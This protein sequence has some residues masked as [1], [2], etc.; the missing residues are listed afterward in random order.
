MSKSSLRRA[1]GLLALILAGGYFGLV[2]FAAACLFQGPA[3]GVLNPVP[4]HHHA[5]GSAKSAHSLLCAWAC[6][7]GSPSATTHVVGV[8][9]TVLA[10]GEVIVWAWT[11]YVRIAWAPGRP[12]SPPLRL[13]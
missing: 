11:V 4:H 9:F 8:P 2:V 13:N 10:W 6:Q 5:D 7:A 12:R 3:P 1:S